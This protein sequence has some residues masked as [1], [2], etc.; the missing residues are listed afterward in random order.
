[1]YLNMT[2]DEILTELKEKYA[3]DEDAMEHINRTETD[4][5]YMKTS[6]Y[7]GSQTPHQRMLELVGFLKT[8]C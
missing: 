5:E 6:Q 4:L 7:K 3:N 2:A 1:M 8:W